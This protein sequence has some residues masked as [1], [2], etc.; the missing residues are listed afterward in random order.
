MTTCLRKS[1][2]FGLP[3]IFFVNDISLCVLY[4]HSR[5][6]VL[7]AGYWIVLCKF[8]LIAFLL[9]F[10]LHSICMAIY[11]SHRQLEHDLL[12][13]LRC[14]IYFHTCLLSITIVSASLTIKMCLSNI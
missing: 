11:L 4:I 9:I 5:L 6:W 14:F 1:G 13:I 8:L 3:C 12:P 7:G 10:L 2:S